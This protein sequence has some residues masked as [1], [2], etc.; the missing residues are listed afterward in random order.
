MPDNDPIIRDPSDFIRAMKKR[1]ED[2]KN[3]KINQ[4]AIDRPE[5]AARY[6]HVDIANQMLKV[7]SQLKIHPLC[8]Q[9][10]TIR[11]LGPY[12]TGKEATHLSIALTLGLRED[13]VK[14]IEM[15][16]IMALDDAL[17]KASSTDF[18]DRFN[19]NKKVDQM[20]NEIKRMG[21]PGTTG[22]QKGNVQHGK[23]RFIV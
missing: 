16:G 5:A 3:R 9:V 13:E 2:A 11:I 20:V 17:Q 12:S 14:E 19:K 21:K 10:M 15:D 7:I 23:E 6:T 1:K 18:V 4:A 22:V 8:K